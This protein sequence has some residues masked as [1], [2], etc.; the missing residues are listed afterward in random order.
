MNLLSNRVNTTRN[1]AEASL[2]SLIDRSFIRNSVHKSRFFHSVCFFTLFAV[3]KCLQTQRNPFAIIFYYSQP[4]EN[5]CTRYFVFW[6]PQSSLFRLFLESPI[7]MSRRQN[8]SQKTDRIIFY[9][10]HG[11]SSKQFL[12]SFMFRTSG[13]MVWINDKGE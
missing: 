1:S 10:F 2:G 13:L 4:G 3:S 12:F 6:A 9:T 7:E 8:R 11:F 5:L